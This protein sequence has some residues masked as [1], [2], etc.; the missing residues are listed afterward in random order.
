M[1]VWYAWAGAHDVLRVLAVL[2][3]CMGSF[4]QRT[5]GGAVK[6]LYA[7]GFDCSR[8]VRFHKA[9]IRHFKIR[10]LI[11]SIDRYTLTRYR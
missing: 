8:V 11:L 9:K 10:R 1:E 6:R 5:V 2:Q 4:F 3:S 7:L